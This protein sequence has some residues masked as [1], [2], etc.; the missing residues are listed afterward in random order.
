MIPVIL[1]KDNKSKIE[2]LEKKK[3]LSGPKYTF[4][5]FA[6]TIR[7]LFANKIKKS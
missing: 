7:K 2:P 1:E 3:F 4:F 6:E 5:Q